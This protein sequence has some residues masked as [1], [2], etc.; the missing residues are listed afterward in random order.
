MTVQ[1]RDSTCRIF[2]P[3]WWGCSILSVKS[4]AQTEGKLVC[5]TRR[6]VHNL[7]SVQTQDNKFRNTVVN[8][9]GFH[10]GGVLLKLPGSFTVEQADVARLSCNAKFVK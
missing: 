8:D 2:Q 1:R 4:P 3:A 7:K 5:E 6:F 10:F 9:A